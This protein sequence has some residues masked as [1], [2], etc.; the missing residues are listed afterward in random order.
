ML[1]PSPAV[2]IKQEDM[3]LGKFRRKELGRDAK[4]SYVAEGFLRCFAAKPFAQEVASLHLDSF[5]RL[6]CQKRL[7]MRRPRYQIC[8]L[9]SPK[10]AFLHV[11]SFIIT[12][13]GPSLQ[14]AGNAANSFSCRVSGSRSYDLGDNISFSRERQMPSPLHLECL[15]GPSASTLY[16]R[17]KEVNSDAWKVVGFSIRA[18]HSNGS[19][20]LGQNAR[21]QLTITNWDGKAD[22][23]L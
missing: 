14:T 2:N 20:A 6:S 4:P 10:L 3:Y 19:E 15:N 1:R 13:H 21:S 8:R 16:S 22:C 23:F 5:R 9:S 7:H 18:S 17:N 12:H 11:P